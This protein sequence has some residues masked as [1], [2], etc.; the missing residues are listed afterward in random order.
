MLTGTFDHFWEW[1]TKISN[2]PLAAHRPPAVTALPFTKVR[3]FS[4]V[5]KQKTSSVETTAQCH[6]S[7][8]VFSS[9][10]KKKCFL[11]IKVSVFFIVS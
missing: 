1:G 9:E 8:D 10:I 7:A 2:M 4:T 6:Y 11:N 3:I 5:N